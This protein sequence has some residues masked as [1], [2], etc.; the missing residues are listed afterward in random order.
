MEHSKLI[1]AMF[2]LGLAACSSSVEDLR[3]FDLDKALAPFSTEADKSRDALSSASLCCWSLS[4]LEYTPL[5]EKSRVRQA[6]NED[7]QVFP[8]VSGDSY[9]LGYQLPKASAPYLLAIDSVATDGVLAPTV[10]ILDANHQVIRQIP[11][12]SFRYAIAEKKRDPNRYR[13]VIQL[14]PS[15]GD[16]YLLVYSTANDMQG[17]VTMVHPRRIENI[18]NGRNDPMM[19]DVELPHSALGAIELYV[20]PTVRDGVIEQKPLFGERSQKVATA[21]DYQGKSIVADKQARERRQPVVEQPK[22]TTAAKVGSDNSAVSAEP[23]EVGFASDTP[24]TQRRMLER[25]ESMY[26]QLIRESI[27]SGQIDVALS[28]VDEAETLGSK[29]ARRTFFD[30]LKTYQP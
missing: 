5:E 10:A 4:E 17:S 23:A 6:L 8:F 15:V 7:T 24:D 9:T 20:N 11:F 16:S 22:T 18:N 3:V 2:S 28:L 13:A 30:T 1:V 14:D 27:Q 19:N 29:S 25:T 12:S 26:N 21:V